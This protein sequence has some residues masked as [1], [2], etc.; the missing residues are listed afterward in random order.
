VRAGGWFSEPAPLP[1]RGPRSLCRSPRSHL[2]SKDRR[3]NQRRCGGNAWMLIKPY[4]ERSFPRVCHRRGCGCLQGR[5]EALG[6]P[7][8]A[9]LWAWPRGCRGFAL[10]CCRG[11][12]GLGVRGVLFH[13]RDLAWLTCLSLSLWGHINVTLLDKELRGAQQ[14]T[15]VSAVGKF[16]A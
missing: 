5:P 15:H 13:C 16:A 14:G 9:C 6:F 10:L 4:L 3:G 7:I 8:Q 12:G 1:E 11:A 2:R